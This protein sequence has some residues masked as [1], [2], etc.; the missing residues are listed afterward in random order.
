[1]NADFKG[2]FY[3]SI[4]IVD[5]KKNRKIQF[6]TQKKNNIEFAYEMNEK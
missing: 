2:K 5:E 6:A 4:E 1:M 3:V